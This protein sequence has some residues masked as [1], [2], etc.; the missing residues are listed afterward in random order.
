[1]KTTGVTFK[2]HPNG[3][4]TEDIFYIKEEEL[5]PLKD[6]EILVKNS[7][8]SVDPYMR[9]KMASISGI[10]YSIPNELMPGD[11]VGEVVESKHPGYKVGDTVCH[12]IGLRTLSTVVPDHSVYKVPDS[13]V[14]N[15]RYLSILG[16]PARGAFT[17][18]TKIL[19][20]EEGKTLSISGATG[21]VGQSL[22]QIAKAKNCNVLAMTSSDKKVEWLESVGA[23]RAVNV[24]GLSP[25]KLN[26]TLSAA[27]SELGG[28]HYHHENVDNRFTLAAMN[29]MSIMSKVAI[30]GIMVQYNNL[31][32]KPGPSLLPTIFKNI[33]L[34]GYIV[35]H[36]EL[37][38]TLDRFFEFMI[39]L[40]KSTN[41]P[42]W[43]ETVYSGL[44]SV[45]KAMVDL[46]TVYP[47]QSDEK[48]GKTII[49][50]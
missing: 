34:Q 17:S 10:G 15:K 6:G 7:D 41:E 47:K 5:N 23:D 39:P 32:P 9:A 49:E 38:D 25:E 11:S 26:K 14:D 4:L 40:V 21:A 24:T 37:R 1:M 2:H 36:Y 18:A 44:E 35:D 31:I 19:N 29:A 20:L 30:C 27:A 3:M 33:T 28:L 46:F 48:N 45:P 8:L 12:R 50:L 22:V 42:R 13:S 16:F 43:R